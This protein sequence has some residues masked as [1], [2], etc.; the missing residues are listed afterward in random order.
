M[1]TEHLWDLIKKVCIYQQAMFSAKV[2]ASRN[3][4]G[5]LEI[6]Q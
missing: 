4:E 3:L 6:L 2:I 5:S 1:R